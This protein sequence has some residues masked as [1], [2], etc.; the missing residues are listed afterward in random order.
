MLLDDPIK[1]GL[2]PDRPI[3]EFCDERAVAERQT[4][5]IERLIQNCIQEA[6]LPL[7]PLKDLP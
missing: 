6:L 7:E 4:A 3:D 1:P 5:L 2:M